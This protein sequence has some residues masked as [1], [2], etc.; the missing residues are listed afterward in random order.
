[1]RKTLALWL[2]W[3]WFFVAQTPLKPESDAV[4]STHVGMFKTEAECKAEQASLKE[5]LEALGIPHRISK[6]KYEQEA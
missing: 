2:V 6:C 3:G 5:M 1:M 4:V